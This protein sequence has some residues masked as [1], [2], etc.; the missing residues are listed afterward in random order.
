MTTCRAWICACQYAL[1]VCMLTSHQGNVC[2]VWPQQRE[3]NLRLRGRLDLL[4]GEN[5]ALHMKVAD[6]KVW[7]FSDSIAADRIA[8]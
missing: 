8:Q 2:N 7:M 5:E 3:R 1:S 6:L 4:L